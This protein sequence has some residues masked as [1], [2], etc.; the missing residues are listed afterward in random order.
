MNHKWKFL[1]K[2]CM[3]GIALIIYLDLASM[4]PFLCI[5]KSRSIAWT[6]QTFTTHTTLNTE[7]NQ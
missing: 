7:Q 3:I 2:E 4:E 6:G 1:G 5:F